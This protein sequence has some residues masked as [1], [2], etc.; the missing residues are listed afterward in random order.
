MRWVGG[1]EGAGGVGMDPP[2]ELLGAQLGKLICE[3]SALGTVSPAKGPAD[4]S[5]FL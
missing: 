5:L 1:G 4:Q 3:A 2:T